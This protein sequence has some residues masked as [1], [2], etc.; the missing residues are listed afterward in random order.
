[1]IGQNDQKFIE[2][3]LLNFSRLGKTS[4]EQEINFLFD[5]DS[6]SR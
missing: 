4:L 5:Y 2:T 1:M 3:I 6:H